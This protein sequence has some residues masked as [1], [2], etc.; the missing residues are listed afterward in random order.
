MPKIIH[1]QV[2]LYIKK[3]VLQYSVQ[4]SI[5]TKFCIIH[6]N[7]KKNTKRNHN[8]KTFTVSFNMIGDSV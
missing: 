6:V 7:Y 4:V 8:T 5:Y 2:H 3:S 1:K